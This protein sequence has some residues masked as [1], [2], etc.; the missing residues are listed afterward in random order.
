VGVRHNA[1]KDAASGEPF[2]QFDNAPF[3]TASTD[4]YTVGDV[5]LGFE[6]DKSAGRPVQLDLSIRNVTDE[7]YRD[8]LDTYKGYAL[9]PGRNVMATVRVPLG[10]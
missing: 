5:G 2:A 10:S 3:G 1:S 8:F 4:S 9:S 7:S 6:L